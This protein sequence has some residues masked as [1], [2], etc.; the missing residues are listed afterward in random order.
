MSDTL[1]LLKYDPAVALLIMANNHL[2]LRM[3]PQYVSI[4]APRAI[5][6]DTTEVTFTSHTSVDRNI[7]S[8]YTGEFDYRYKRIDVNDIFAGMS[9]DLMPP[10]TIRGIINNLSL[11]TGLVVTA[12]DFENGL[13][14]GSFFVLK[15]KPGSLRWVGET[16]VVLNEPGETIDLA[17]AFS[18]NILNGLWAPDFGTDIPLQRAIP[19]PI[20]DGLEYSAQ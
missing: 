8:L 13:V 20:M 16:T 12:D 10:A 19:E 9:L 14:E 6:F 4:S 15:A 2:N 3:M 7:P 17:E 11:A 5:D 18:N 1:R